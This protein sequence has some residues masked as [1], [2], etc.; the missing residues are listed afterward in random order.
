LHFIHE[1]DRA[2]LHQ[3]ITRGLGTFDRFADV[4]DPAQHGADADELRVKGIGHQARDGR[5]AHTRRTP[6]DAAVR[7]ARLEREPQRHARAQHMLLPDHLAQRAGPQALGQGLVGR[8]V[9]LGRCCG[10]TACCHV[11]ILST[12]RWFLSQIG[13]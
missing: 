2:L 5:L 9:G 6:E 10:G 8:G 7:A 12:S 4:L 13:L 11:R 1:D 3:T